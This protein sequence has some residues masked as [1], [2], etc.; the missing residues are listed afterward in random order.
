MRDSRLLLCLSRAQ[1]G[2]LAAVAC[3]L[4][5]ADA[6]RSEPTTDADFRFKEIDDKSLALWEGERPVLVYRFGE[7]SLPKVR[8]AGTRSS[9]V[10][11]IYGLEG[12]VLTDDFPVDHY[13]HHGLF[14]G[15][16]HVMVGGREYDLWKMRGISIDF[17]S[18]LAKDADAKQA[19]LGVENAWMVRDRPVI[20]EEVWFA[21]H[22][23]TEDERII[24][25]TLSWTPVDE[26]VTLVGA[27]D[28]SYGGLTLRF[29][30]RTGTTITTPK[31]VASEDLLM[32]HL[33]WADLTAK[34]KGADDASGAAI[35]VN[36]KHPQFPPQW[37]TR[38]YGVLAVGWPGIKSVTLA[39]QQTIKCR[40][41][42][43]IHKGKRDVMQIAK[44]FDAYAGKQ[45]QHSAAK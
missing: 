6:A 38:D 1:I 29:A 23:A 34:F 10:H 40:Y 39:P 44:A 18:W 41:R 43:W 5:G 8:A 22:P 9:Y 31:G 27:E 42:V 4:I 7:M 16:P 32:K 28:K 2:A 14:W 15:W 26:P 36:P 30:P 20:K 17:K 35:F 11:P 3:L 12:E 33:P 19:R 25:V 37:M 13:H 45:E 24:D 21:I